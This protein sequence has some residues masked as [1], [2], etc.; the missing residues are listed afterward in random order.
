MHSTYTA[1]TECRHVQVQWV[2]FNAEDLTCL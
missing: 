2:Y 1:Q